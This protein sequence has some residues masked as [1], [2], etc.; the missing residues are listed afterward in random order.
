MGIQTPYNQLDRMTY[1]T[2]FLVFGSSYAFYITFLR[3]AISDNI[4]GRWSSWLDLKLRSLY[5]ILND[6]ADFQES[7]P[8]LRDS[9]S[10]FSSVSFVHSIQ[11]LLKKRTR[12]LYIFHYVMVHKLKLPETYDLSE[13]LPIEHICGICSSCMFH[14]RLRAFHCAYQLSVKFKITNLLWCCCYWLLNLLGQLKECFE[15]EDSQVAELHLQPN[16]S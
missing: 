8:Q 16:D 12:F 11:R 5:H 10:N 2:D 1:F 13:C 7:S 15:V 6:H 9:I 4:L 3:S 14:S